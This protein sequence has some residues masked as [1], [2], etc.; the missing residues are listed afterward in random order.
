MHMV[1]LEI[2]KV[3]SDME[4]L[5]RLEYKLLQQGNYEEWFQT[6]FT[7]DIHYHMPVVS[8]REN[9]DEAV[10]SENELSYFDD[11][12]RT[13]HLRVRKF[14]SDMSWTEYPPSR[15]RYFFQIMDVEPV[16]SNVFRVTSNI[17]LY[18]T[19]LDNVE[20][21]FVGEKSDLVR[22]ENGQWKV[23]KR[24]IIIDKSRLSAHSLCVFF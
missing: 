21:F 15:T 1:D 18:F 5:Y 13:L 23:T 20:N 4:K 17:M 7:E 19:R 12:H 2:D 10:R 9:R 14:G 22:C 3:W 16:E 11:N 8:V 6:M 24:K